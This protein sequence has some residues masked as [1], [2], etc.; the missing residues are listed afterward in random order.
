MSV[1]VSEVSAMKQTISSI[2]KALENGIC[3]AKP[4]PY[5]QLAGLFPEAIL[6]ELQTLSF[7]HF[8]YSDG[9]GARNV[10]DKYR[11]YFNKDNNKK[12]YALGVV[13]EAFQSSDVVKAVESHFKVNLSGTCLRIE[14]TQ[15]TDGFWLKPHT[16]IGAKLFT[17]L[18]YL[19]DGPGHDLLGTDIY[20]SPSEHVG[21]SVALPNHAMAFVPSDKTWHGFEKRSIQGVRKTAIVNYVTADWRARHELAFPESPV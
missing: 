12:H 14:F 11:H 5:W 3:A 18:I 1:V 2:K 19:S 9:Y 4:Y 7:P 6:R 21:S 13:A 8:D 17:M 20:A 10:Y 15:D 16:D